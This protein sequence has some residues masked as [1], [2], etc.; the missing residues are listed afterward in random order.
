MRETGERLQQILKKNSGSCRKNS[1]K[2]VLSEK[3]EEECFK[4]EKWVLGMQRSDK[5]NTEI[6]L[7][8]FAI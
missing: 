1:R 5:I 4:N 7:L 8:G 6:V 3:L 2:G